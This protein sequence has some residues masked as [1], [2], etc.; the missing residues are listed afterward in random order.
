[1]PAEQRLLLTRRWFRI[2]LLPLLM[3]FPPSRKSTS[4]S[5][6]YHSKPPPES[7]QNFARISVKPPPESIQASA[8]TILRTTFGTPRL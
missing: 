7:I 4:S 1:M 3:D 8:R 5:P 2:G 6:Q